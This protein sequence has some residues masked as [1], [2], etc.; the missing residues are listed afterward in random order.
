ML[1]LF[2]YMQEPRNAELME[3]TYY[4]EADAK[5]VRG[6]GYSYSFSDL[7]GTNIAEGKNATQ[8]STGYGCSA[9]R[10]VDGNV[11]GRLSRGSV[12][13]TAGHGS[14]S[15]LS[16]VSQLV[17]PN[18][19][20]QVDLG[21]TTSIGT[22]KVWN[23]EEEMN[24]DEVQTV[25]VASAANV[26]GSFRLSFT[27]SYS[28]GRVPATVTA[29]TS[30]ISVDAVAMISDEVPGSTLAGQGPGESM[31]AKLQVR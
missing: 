17:E 20:W 8:S 16:G 14:T 13:H 12:T 26:S 6:D 15:S 22:I 5:E 21:S 7:L 27:R 11:D 29:T 19:W 23:Q 3:Q 24:V 4:P 10:A 9:D 25:T 18:P 31:Q 1:T 28:D 2:L 30:D